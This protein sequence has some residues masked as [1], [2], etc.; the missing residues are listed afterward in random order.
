MFFDLSKLFVQAQTDILKICVFF[1]VYGKKIVFQN[2]YF[3]G[4]FWK[5]KVLFGKKASFISNKKSYS[6]AP[7]MK[8]AT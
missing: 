4:P 7:T 2:F 5:T 6:V 3:K 8:L 1:E